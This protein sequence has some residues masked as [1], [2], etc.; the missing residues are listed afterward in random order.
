LYRVADSFQII[1]VIGAAI[2]R[3]VAANYVQRA[4][5]QVTLLERSDLASVNRP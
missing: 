3:L 2:N 5:H 1:A 4:E